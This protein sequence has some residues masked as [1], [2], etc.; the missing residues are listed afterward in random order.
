MHLGTCWPIDAAVAY[1]LANSWG[2]RSTY[3]E[4][5]GEPKHTHGSGDDDR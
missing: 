2:E 3:L 1:T 4:R 5:Y